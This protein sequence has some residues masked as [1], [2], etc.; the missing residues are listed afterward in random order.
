[1]PKNKKKQESSSGDSDEGPVDVSS[2]HLLKIQ[3][4]NII[5]ISLFNNKN[6]LNAMSSLTRGKQLNWCMF[7]TLK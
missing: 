4:T 3:Q 7:I 2:H 6:R 1:M 5:Q